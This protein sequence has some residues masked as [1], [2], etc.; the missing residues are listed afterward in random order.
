MPKFAA[1]VSL[2]FTELPFLERFKAAADAGF[3]GV[4][5]L[6]PYAWSD[7][8]I[9]AKL[10]DNDL[11]LVLFNI[12]PG[13][14]DDGER[15]L[16]GVKGREAD[17][18][19]AVDQALDYAIALG[20]RKL[21]AMAGLKSHG[22][23][24]KTYLANLEKAAARAENH[25]VDILIEPINTHDFPGYLLNT[26]QDAVDIIHAVGATNLGLQFDLY[27]RHMM[28]GE[29]PRALDQFGPFA[30]HIQVAGPPDRGE[31][32]PS[33]VDFIP[34]FQKIDASGYK[35]WIGCEYKPRAGT[36]EG[37]SWLDKVTHY[38]N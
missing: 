10:A 24:Q 15:G 8:E 20:C 17:F 36:S 32:I 26:T 38:T 25:G 37:L 5:M 11:Q 12:Y 22:A 33:Q 2:M 4:E 28:E 1:N 29:V 6:F 27:H 14:W 13:A 18:E 3:K 31:P 23:N 35:G 30:R 21:H 16:T 34:L 7:A 9:K 19:A